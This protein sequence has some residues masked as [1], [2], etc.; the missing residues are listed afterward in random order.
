[1]VVWFLSKYQSGS[2]LPL[3]RSNMRF[4]VLIFTV[5]C[6]VFVMSL[7]CDFFTCFDLNVCAIEFKTKL[8]LKKKQHNAQE[9]CA[10]IYIYIYKPILTRI[11]V[12]IIYAF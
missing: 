12:I 1:M 2:S 3:V 4:I 11:S 6:G 10:F 7:M 8:F 9:T 5:G